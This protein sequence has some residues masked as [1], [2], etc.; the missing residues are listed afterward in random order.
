M[1]EKCTM[2]INVSA[3]SIEENRI[4][5]FRRGNTL[6]NTFR[7]QEEGILGIHFQQGEISDE[8]GYARARQNLALNRPYPFTLETGVRSRDMTERVLTN[9]QLMEYTEEAL[10]YVHSEFPEFTLNGGFA[11]S[12]LYFGQENDRG[13]D[14][15]S[16]DCTT[17]FRLSFKHKESRE[18]H[19]GWFSIGQRDF[20]MQKFRAMA[21]NYLTAFGLSRDFPKEILVQMRYYDLLSLFAG[22][23]NAESICLGTSLLSGRLGEKLFAEHFSLAH[24]VSDAECWN[25]PFFDGEGV[26]QKGDRMLYIENGVVL[27]GY[28]DKRIAR[29]YGVEHT[30]SAC[31]ACA[32]LPY[33]G[34]VNLRIKCSDK[35]VRELLNGSL[36]VVPIRYGGGGF[37]EKGEWVMPVQLGYLCDGE[38]LLGRL[39]EFTLVSNLFDMFGEDFIGVGCDNPVFHDKSILV[40]MRLGKSRG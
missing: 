4:D 31:S 5:S 20:D 16:R 14:Y 39:P 8:E 23:L 19:D 7:V 2:R 36:S 25:T 37:N 35:T 15:S 28:A 33:N 1:R 32:D 29:K 21:D 22:S 26:V 9:R 13:L 11:Q 40:R 18:L 6:I 10:E 34:N 38:R 12:I 24:D 27:R 17:E 30:G 3:V